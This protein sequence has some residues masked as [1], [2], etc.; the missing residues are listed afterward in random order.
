MKAK[1]TR[2]DQCINTK[3]VVSENETK[4]VCSLPQNAAMDCML[5]TKDYANILF[6]LEQKTRCAIRLKRKTLNSA[7]TAV[8][9]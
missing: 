4:I 1:E 2:C 8:L 6:F 3:L 5:G 9:I 7:P